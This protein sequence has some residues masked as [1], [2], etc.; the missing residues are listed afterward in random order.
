VIKMG[1][2]KKQSHESIKAKQREISSPYSDAKPSEVTDVYWLFAERKQG[3]CLSYTPRG[4][5]WLIFVNIKDIDE[6]WGKIKKATEEGKLGGSA[7]VATARP[8]PNATNPGTKVICVYT[9]DWTD[10]EDVRK[11]RK[12]LR[13]LGITNKIPY[14]ADED[15]LSG[16]YRVKGH[17][18]ISKY[19]E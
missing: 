2:E 3:K 15:T 12:E 10:E 11:I 6:V 4:G 13:K 19:Y 5:K 7:K 1:V 18:R 8:N 9:Y 16:K 14:K 17:T